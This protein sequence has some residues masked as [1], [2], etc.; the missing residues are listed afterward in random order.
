LFEGIWVWI[1]ITIIN[2]ILLIFWLNFIL[3]KFYIFMKIC[4]MSRSGN[5]SLIFLLICYILSI[6]N[7]FYKYF[8]SVKHRHYKDHAPLLA[9]D[10]PHPIFSVVGFIFI[11]KQICNIFKKKKYN[12]FLLMKISK[13]T[14]FFFEQGCLVVSNMSQ[15]YTKL[16][17]EP[18]TNVSNLFSSN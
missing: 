1:T 8:P 2:Q 18:W 12:I 9:R 14:S 15:F 16:T 3:S 6:K 13:F 7:T 5:I 11:R 4:G 10:A 17:K